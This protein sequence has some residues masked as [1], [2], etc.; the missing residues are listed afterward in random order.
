MPKNELFTKK[1][2]DDIKIFQRNM[3]GKIYKNSFDTDNKNEVKKLD[4][5]SSPIITSK[6]LYDTNCYNINLNP[7]N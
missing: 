7:L 6:K 4:D 3:S 5:F 1:V 2:K